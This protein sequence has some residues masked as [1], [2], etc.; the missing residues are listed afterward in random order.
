MYSTRFRILDTRTTY[1]ARLCHG[2]AEISV[3]ELGET[4]AEG[5]DLIIELEASVWGEIVLGLT[6]LSD[7]LRAGRLQV[8]GDL[9]HFTALCRALRTGVETP[10]STSKKGIDP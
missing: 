9:L 7:A 10:L 5:A 4:S 1:A 6:C 3:A 8:R 2:V